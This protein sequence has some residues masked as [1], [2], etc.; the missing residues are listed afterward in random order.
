MQG[1]PL[2]KKE[3]KQFGFLLSSIL[4]LVGY[5]FF[6]KEHVTAAI[7][8]LG[9]SLTILVTTIFAP[10]L[11]RYIQ[12]PWMAFARFMNDIVTAI[13]MGL[14]FYIFFTPYALLL[15]LFK[16]KFL[17]QFP[18]GAATYWIDKKTKVFNSVEEKIQSYE[19]QF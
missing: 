1:S 16:I 2:S 12:K 9:F 11:L 13:M 5:L 8:C 3:L 10:H 7:Y 14:V 18:N 4:L 19:R 17:K 15:K 6:H